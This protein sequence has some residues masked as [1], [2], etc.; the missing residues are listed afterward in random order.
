MRMSLMAVLMLVGWLGAGN[1]AR[2]GDV[3]NFDVS[4]MQLGMSVG[5]IEAAAAAKGLLETARMKAPWFEQAVMIRKK[6][7]V[8]ARNYGGIRKLEFETK[9][10][11]VEVDFVAM[12][13]GPRAYMIHYV[14]S[15]P[16]L[17][18]EAMSAGVER[19]YGA[20]DKRGEL[21]WVWG[22]VATIPL[23]TE[24]NLEYKIEPLT[25]LVGRKAIGSLTLRDP[26]LPKESQAAIEEAA[27]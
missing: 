25:T 16:S 2:A 1:V 26:G 23:R 4:G 9:T 5:E 3:R 18:S 14:N 13:E 7:T 8:E 15:D 6:R 12:P 22:D 10:E 11:H 17:S 21:K 19:K 27:S 20:P 24:P